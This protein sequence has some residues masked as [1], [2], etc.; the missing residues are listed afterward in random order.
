MFELFLSYPPAQSVPALIVEPL[1]VRFASHEQTFSEDE[2][3]TLTCIAEGYPAPRL[4]W[5]IN[6]QDLVASEKVQINGKSRILN[7]SSLFVEN[8]Y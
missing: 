1:A 3:L 4:R 7:P 8:C 5:F 6:D 2:S